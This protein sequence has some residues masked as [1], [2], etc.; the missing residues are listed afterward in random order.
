MAGL[1]RCRLK[2]CVVRQD[3]VRELRHIVAAVALAS[4]VEGAPL[5]ARVLRQKALQEGDAVLQQR[6]HGFAD[7]VVLKGH[8]LHG[9]LNASVTS[10]SGAL[11]GQSAAARRLHARMPP[12][13]PVHSAW[14]AAVW[15]SHFHVSCD[16]RA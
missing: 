16:V 10:C 2:P 8:R 7:E 9:H 1:L 4:K 15:S 3:G 5:E 14:A 12:G 13:G 6:C 11:H